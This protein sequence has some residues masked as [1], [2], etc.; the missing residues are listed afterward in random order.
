MAGHAGRPARFDLLV[1]TRSSLVSGPWRF[2]AWNMNFH[3]EHHLAPQMPFHALPKL[4]QLVAERI[5]V[6]K[7]YRAAHGEIRRLMKVQA[8]AL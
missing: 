6:G 8:R 4:H 3:A 7:G 2:I 1:N 5:P